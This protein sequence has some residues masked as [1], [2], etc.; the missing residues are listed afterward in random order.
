MNTI[1]ALQ[2]W[3][4]PESGPW[5]VGQVLIEADAEDR[6]RFWLR[7]EK[8]AGREN[9]EHSGDPFRMRHWVREDEAGEFRPLKGEKNLP[10]GWCIGPLNLGQ[11]RECLDIVYPTA[12]AN[13]VYW[14]AGKLSVTPFAETAGRQTGMYRITGLTNE[15]QREAVTAE[16]CRSRCLKQRLWN[17]ERVEDGDK[18]VLPL[19]CPE[20]CNL[21]IAACRAKIKG[22]AEEE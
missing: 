5:S 11:L 22:K 9:L 20:V 6:G 10:G 15:N 1:E 17:G 14:Q 7:H 4:R 3:L 21:F 2:Q 12:L 16:L 19:L 13:W 18:A 8:D